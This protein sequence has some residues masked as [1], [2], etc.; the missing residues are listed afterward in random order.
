MF[1][2]Q[3]T[4]DD[5][6]KLKR[7]LPT[8]TLAGEADKLKKTVNELQK[9]FVELRHFLAQAGG[10]LQSETPP[11]IISK[12]VRSFTHAAQDWIDAGSREPFMDALSELYFLCRNYMLCEEGFDGCCTVLMEAREPHVR[13]RIYCMD[14]ATR[15]TAC[16]EKVRSAVF[17]SA[18]LSPIDYFQRMLGL[19]ET[20]VLQLPSPFPRENLCIAAVEHLPTAYKQRE[21]SLT[22]LCRCLRDMVCAH[23]G[24]YFAFFP[25]YQYMQLAHQLF[26]CL[27]PDIDAPIQASGMDD[28]ARQQFLERFTPQE[29]RSMLAFAVMGGLFSEGIDLVGDRLSGAAIVGV[30]LPQMDMEGNVLR[31]YHDALDE[32]GFAYAYAYPGFNRVMQAAGRVIRTE[33]DR[34]VVLLIDPR[35]AQW[36]YQVLFPDH[37]HPLPCINSQS[38]VQNLLQDFWETKPPHDTV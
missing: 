16:Y 4:W 27:F 22:G 10:A 24:C 25:S 37:W 1:S 7:A 31:A 36:R 35:F 5:V 14:P 21:S 15:L 17:F 9:A 12:A 29:G 23:P 8:G 34:G 38:A 11:E 26:T 33:K 30:G 20:P 13:V 19:S 2:A 3:L 32:D 28:E 6:M 18:T